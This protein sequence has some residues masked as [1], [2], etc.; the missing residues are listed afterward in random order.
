MNHDIDAL[1][2]KIK[3]LHRTLSI[4]AGDSEI[5]E[6]LKYIHKPGYTTPAE[7]ILVTAI[8]ENMTTHAGALV[9]LRTALLEGSREITEEAGRE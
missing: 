3:E 6:L 8:V 4:L 2:G 1:H 9:Q 7:F 5:D